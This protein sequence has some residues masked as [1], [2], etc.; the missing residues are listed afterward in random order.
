MLLLLLK[1]PSSK[2]KSSGHLF[3]IFTS[4]F[5]CKIPAP[6]RG[7]QYATGSGTYATSWYTF[8]TLIVFLALKL[9]LKVKAPSALVVVLATTALVPGNHGVGSPNC[10]N[11][12]GVDRFRAALTTAG[13]ARV[14]VDCAIDCAGDTDS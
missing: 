14:S 9:T 13:L 10:Q 7:V 3:V 2:A 5:P 6:E 4:N 1:L 8:L 11:D 12:R